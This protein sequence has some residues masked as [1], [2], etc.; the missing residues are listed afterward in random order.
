MTDFSK[1]MTDESVRNF[2]ELEVRF[3]AI[4]KLEADLEDLQADSA[5]K[6]QLSNLELDLA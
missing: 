2:E 1:E 6:Y 5:R 3:K 4:P